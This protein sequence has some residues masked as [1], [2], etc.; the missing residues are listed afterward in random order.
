LGR[1]QEKVFL[2]GVSSSGSIAS[3]APEYCAVERATGAPM[4]SQ[5]DRDEDVAHRKQKN[6][7][8]DAYTKCLHIDFDGEGHC[9]FPFEQWRPKT[10]SPSG[11]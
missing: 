9:S 7:V 2:A 4:D 3:S 5:A 6:S 11:A 10:L 8:I 1:Q